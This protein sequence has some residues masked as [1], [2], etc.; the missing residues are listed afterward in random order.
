VQTFENKSERPLQ[1]QE[2]NAPHGCGFGAGRRES[3]P[4]R[5]FVRISNWTY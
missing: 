5:C 2:P 1:A 3:Q 4:L